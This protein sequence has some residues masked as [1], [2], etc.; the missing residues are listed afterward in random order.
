MNCNKIKDLIYLKEDELTGKESNLLHAHLDEC[1]L[2]S[3]EYEENKKINSFINGIRNTVPVMENKELFADS[4]ID[5]L[6]REPKRNDNTAKEK[7]TSFIEFLFTKRLVRAAAFATILLLLS[8]YIIQQLLV[9]HYV[10]LLENKASIAAS[11]AVVNAGFVTGDA[12]VIKTF[13]GLFGLLS[14]DHM[15]A[16]FPKGMI[17]A[18]KS[19][20]NEFLSLYS[21]LQK[22]KDANPVIFREKYPELNAFLME[23]LSVEGLQN[24]VKKN[25][26]LIKELS[27]NIP[28]GGK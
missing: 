9:L 11:A 15:F 28:A 1:N 10:E 21:T 20:L 12:D 8:T 6:E 16:E 4:V 7:I 19:K 24:F 22:Y 13:S 3:A 18:D 26:D 5:L 25:M 17:L 14:G 27:R 2:C 23:K